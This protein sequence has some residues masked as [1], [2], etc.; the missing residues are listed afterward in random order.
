M[1]TIATDGN[2]IAADGRMVHRDLIISDDEWK[3]CDLPDGSIVGAAGDVDD[4]KAALRVLRENLYADGAAPE[5]DRFTLLRLY[6]SGAIQHY[7]GSLNGDFID[8]PAAAGSGAEIAL[9]AMLAGKSPTRA[10]K[11]AATR[12]IYSGGT[13]RTLKVRR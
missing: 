8:P 1:T 6:P 10:V 7:A 5:G 2:S 4:I 11:I 3:L 12:D 13:V 9:G